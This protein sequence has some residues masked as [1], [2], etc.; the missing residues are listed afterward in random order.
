MDSHSSGLKEGVV[1]NRL[2]V[3][4]AIKITTS[5]TEVLV[6]WVWFGQVAAGAASREASL[7]GASW[8]TRDNSLKIKPAND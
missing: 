7:S 5:D 3:N 8:K 2:P 1:D 6:D 4:R